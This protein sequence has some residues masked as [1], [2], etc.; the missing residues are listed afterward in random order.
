MRYSRSKDAVKSLAF[1]GVVELI[2]W[3]ALDYSLSLWILQPNF[4]ADKIPQHVRE[5]LRPGYENLL[6]LTAQI[7]GNIEIVAWTVFGA[8]QIIALIW[9][10][11]SILARVYKPGMARGHIMFYVFVLVVSVLVGLLVACDG[12]LW[13]I[14]QTALLGQLTDDFRAYLIVGTTLY[15]SFV[16]LIATSI[17]VPPVMRRASLWGTAFG[18]LTD[19]LWEI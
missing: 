1:F 18:R 3:F 10:V 12:Y 14:V 13:G 5:G 9:L 17:A 8:T 6:R 19:R 16:F 7:S 11:Y 15:C 2:L 4:V